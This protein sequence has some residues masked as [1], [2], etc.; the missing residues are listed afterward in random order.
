M[1]LSALFMLELSGA[2]LWI[3]YKLHAAFP[4]AQV[5]SLR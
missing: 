1:R 4:S 2:D 3:F 5:Y